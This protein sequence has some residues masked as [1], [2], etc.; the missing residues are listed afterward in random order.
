M[1]GYTPGKRQENITVLA[2]IIVIVVLLLFARIHAQRALTS[3]SSKR[4]F[5]FWKIRTRELD[6]TWGRYNQDISFLS[7]WFFLTTV[8]ALSNRVGFQFV[9]ACTQI[10]LLT[11]SICIF[12]QSWL[13]ILLHH[14]CPISKTRVIFPLTSINIC[15]DL[16]NDLAHAIMKI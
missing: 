16:K 6:D 3:T 13:S 9:C 8:L 14:V 11:K 15:R 12:D 7:S 5:T 2:I 4:Y 1:L 10:Q